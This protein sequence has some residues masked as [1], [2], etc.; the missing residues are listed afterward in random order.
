MTFPTVG[1]PVPRQ[2]ADIHEPL[3]FA[4][5]ADNCG[6]EQQRSDDSGAAE[7]ARRNGGG[8]VGPQPDPKPEGVQKPPS[9]DE[10]TEDRSVNEV[11]PTL[12]FTVVST[13]SAMIGSVHTATTTRAQPITLAMALTEVRRS[14]NPRTRRDRRLPRSPPRPRRRWRRWRWRRDRRRTRQPPTPPRAASREPAAS[15]EACSRSPPGTNRPGRRVRR[16]S[17]GTVP[18]RPLPSRCR[19]MPASFEHA[20][21]KRQRHHLV[22]IAPDDS[23]VVSPSSSPDDLRTGSS[24]P[25]EEQNHRYP[26]DQVHDLSDV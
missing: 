10:L 7:Q 11:E 17:R 6:D 22:E 20:P 23:S 16:R 15:E 24:G 8:P 9:D 3:H 2:P 26:E 14:T 4:G 1:Q 12:S 13:R 25:G 19:R 5:S 18:R 21:R